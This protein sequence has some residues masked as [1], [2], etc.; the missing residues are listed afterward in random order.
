MTVGRI[1]IN[2]GMVNATSIDPKAAE[3]DGDEGA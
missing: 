2:G 1:C 3:K